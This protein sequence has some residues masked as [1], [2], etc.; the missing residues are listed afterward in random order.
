MI[1]VLFPGQGAQYSGMGAELFEQYPDLTTEAGDVL[2]YAIDRL[3]VQDPNGLLSKTR[4]TQPALYVVNALSYRAWRAAHGNS[5]DFAAGHSL[6]EYNAL[7]AA[8]VFDF[9]TGLRLVARR[10]EL[11][12][13]APAGAMAVVVG[14]AEERIAAVLRDAQLDD[15][16]IANHNT[17][18]QFVISGPERSVARAEALCTGAGADMYAKL[19]VSGPFHSRYMRDAQRQ[20]AAHVASAPLAEPR[21]PVVSNVTA[22][23]HGP[24]LSAD[25][26]RQLSS[27]VRW[28]ESIRHLIGAGVDTFRQVGVG[29]AL[30]SM[31]REIRAATATPVL[32]PSTP[33]VPDQRW[34]A[35]RV[36]QD[37]LRRARE[38][39]RL[40]G[41]G[42]M[43]DDDLSTCG[44]DLTKLIDLSAELCETL[45]LKVPPAAFFQYRTVRGLARHLVGQYGEPLAARYADG[46]GSALRPPHAERPSAEASARPAARPTDAPPRQPSERRMHARTQV[47]H[48]D[49]P[50][51]IAIVGISGVLPGA[52]DLDHFWQ[53]LLAGRDV[54]TR[55]PEERWDWRAPYGRLDDG[56]RHVPWG[57]FMRAPD[58]FDCTFFGISPQEAELMD[59]QQRL[60]LQT[61]WRAV[62]DSGHQ[63]EELASC[64]TGVFVGASAIDY[65]EV[66]SAA[67]RDIEAHTVTGLAHSLLANRVSHW[68]G[69]RGPSE[70]VDTACSSSL[71]A[72]HRAMCS[73]RLGDCD[74]AIVGGV[75]V[76]AGPGTFITLSKARMLAPD[77]R[78]KTFDVRANGYV[79]GEGVVALLI[80]PLSHA[81]RDGDH[82]HAL[83]RGSAVN[84]SGPTMSLTVPDPNAQAEVVAAAW[85]TAGLDPSTAGL[86][87][88]HGTGTALG[89]PI[90]I[91]GLR[92]A[93]ARLYAEW[94]LPAPSHQHVAVGAVKSHIGHLEPAAGSA[95]LATV[96]LAMR[97]GHLPGLANFET[98]N[99][100]L[101]LAGS[102]LR[103]PTGPEPWERLKDT[104]GRELPRRAGVS[105]FGFG[106]A[107]AHVV[108]EEYIADAH[109]PA[110]PAPGRPQLVPQQ[111]TFAPSRRPART[112]TAPAESP[113]TPSTRTSSRH[114]E[115]TH[116][117]PLLDGQ[118]LPAAALVPLSA[119]APERLRARAEQLVAWLAEHSSQDYSFADLVA[120]LQ[121]GRRAM[122][123]RLAVLTSDAATL[124]ARLTRFLRDGHADEVWSGAVSPLPADSQDDTGDQ[125][126]I[127][128]LAER[129][130]LVGVARLWTAGVPLDWGLLHPG[131][132]PRRL[133][134][135][136]YPFEERRLWPRRAAPAS[137]PAAA[138]EVSTPV[139]RTP[140][141]AGQGTTGA[142]PSGRTVTKSREQITEHLIQV[143]TDTLGWRRD[144]LDQ[145]TGFDRLGLDSLASQLIRARL[146]KHYGKLPATLVF[147]YK[148]V[149]SLSGYLAN[150]QAVAAPTSAPARTAPIT[151]PP[152]DTRA[153]DIAVI[154][155]SGRYPRARSVA[156]FWQ[157]L[158][159]GRDCI[160]EIPQDRPGFGRYAELARQRYGDAWH[161]WGGWLKDVD[162][163]DAPFFRI[164][165]IE[166]RYLDPQQ[167]LFLEV[168]WE[169]VEDAGYTPAALA[170]AALADQRGAVGVFAGVT[171]NNYQLFGSAALERGEWLA[172]E[173]QTF[174]VANRVSY[175]M[176]F[177]GPSLTVDTACSSSLY[178]VHLA[179][180]SIRRGECTAALA[181]G[182][183][184]S[185]H[186]AKFMTL[187]ETGF[188]SSDGR[189]RAF[190]EGGDGYVPA[191]A[192]GAV[193]L[194]S[195]GQ[196]LRDGDDIHAV[197]KGSAVNS[198]GRTF[199]Y[200]VPNPVAQT[201]V[202]QAA[203][204]SAGV[205]PETI[206]YVE[207]H[208]TGTSLGDPIELRGLT[209][210]FAGVTARQSCAI[211]SVKSAIG[212]AESSAGIAQLTKVVLQLRHRQLAPTLLHSAR[213]NPEI[214]FEETPFRVQL[215]AGPWDAPT[216][217]HPRRAGVSSFGAG[218]VNVHLVLEEAPEAHRAP[219]GRRR[220]V[221]LLSAAGEPN[222]RDYA[223]RLRRF[224]AE[225]GPDSQPGG[226]DAFLLDVAHTLQTGRVHLA[227]R[228]AFTASEPAEAIA[229]LDA[230][231]ASDADSRVHTG[232]APRR[233]SF[234][235]GGPLRPPVGQDAEELARAW[236]AGT[237]WAWT[238]LYRA[239]PK[240]RR[241]PLP[242]YPFS[243]RRYWL[244][245]QGSVPATP[246]AV[247][248]ATDAATQITPH[249]ENGAKS[250]VQT[251]AGLVAAVRAAPP[252][253]RC[254]LLVDHLRAELGRLLQYAPEE[255]PD[256]D[257]GFFD[258]GLDS[259]FA[260]RLGTRIEEELGVELYATVTFDYP[261]IGELAPYLLS[262]MD[263]DAPA[264]AP[265]DLPPE[266]PAERY[267]TLHYTADWE[268]EPVAHTAPDDLAEVWSAG[269]V[270]L[271][272]D[273][274]V[275]RLLRAR[276]R[277]RGCQAPV[278][279][280]R[281]GAAYACDSAEEYRVRP[282]A[283]DDW[284]RLLSSLGASRPRLPGTFV[285]LWTA[286]SGTEA[287]RTSQRR[288]DLGVRSQ[289][290][291]ARSLMPRA[292]ELTVRVLHVDAYGAA[293]PD[294]LAEA[295]SGFARSLRHENPRLLYQAVALDAD[296]GGAR[297]DPQDVL[298]VCT[299]ELRGSGQEADVRYEGGLRLVRRVR[300]V[301]PQ[302][303][304][305]PV[306]G[307]VDGGVYVITGGAGGLGLIFAEHL[308]RRARV[309]LVLS[310][311]SELDAERNAAVAR[312]AELGA[313]VT[314]VRA[315][316]GSEDGARS[317]IEQ[318]RDRHGRIDG[319]IHSAGH[320]KDALLVNKSI[321]DIDAVLAGKVL[322]ALH[323]DELTRDDDLA[324]FMTFSSLT[325]LVGNPGQADYAYANR[326]LCA[327]ARHRDRLRL[328]GERS[329]RS[330]A[331]VWPSWRHGGM[332]ADAQTEEAL[333]RHLGLDLLDTPTGTEA[334][335]L[336]LA[337]AQSEFGVIRADRARLTRVLDVLPPRG[338]QEAVTGVD[339][340]RELQ[341]VLE[342]IGL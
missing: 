38:V 186:P 36:E 231:L 23:P 271:D 180:E 68:M 264:A 228:L 342:E 52:D 165:P 116:R 340:R 294:P 216:A 127:G 34:L 168:A 152:A 289:F 242:T 46:P 35:A 224:L 136:T 205:G 108:L 147:T 99:P 29:R 64:R 265:A 201:E 188:L 126:R 32:A 329:G 109:S 33:T 75:N 277:A 318:A 235:A 53:N 112:L 7:E 287:A 45:A 179:C 214:P 293:G 326:F 291:L 145:D 51:P 156:E 292:R 40:A 57:A 256:P 39:L 21:F 203:L 77:G 86:I 187:A 95:G 133:P 69:L 54:I 106:G 341:G 4:W 171:Y 129:G 272:T 83:L 304:N 243:R 88:A 177:G 324:F 27:P 276:L 144:E 327:F 247:K 128:A 181:G 141:S 124:Q 120:T 82:I 240:P 151:A 92:R 334:F 253:E 58:A 221:L 118:T 302:R 13:R 162:A 41:P 178:A 167:R 175:L 315:D 84:H 161:R 323:L 255:P 94:G 17:P 76:M 296:H 281:P 25:L 48:R 269:V 107:N 331:L 26:V 71:A 337:S 15:V 317:L 89:D 223:A 155:M 322:G 245:E 285:H 105:S 8:G 252:S 150:R 286:T 197:I 47:E 63:V 266:Q 43:P 103:L 260:V 307:P 280:V 218:G 100:L 79:R 148:N 297:P 10:A 321:E 158:L 238:E 101:R 49:S 299:A 316:V 24:D 273:D 157:N 202:I 90:E 259:V 184:L 146:E 2:G 246:P 19:K 209:D 166:A 42:P 113:R 338:S 233:T 9:A 239:G 262:L 191:E 200:S 328:A 125:A 173:T 193:L 335:D 220:H 274:A 206:G 303:A 142:G 236:A 278:V 336:A 283:A 130:D 192:V 210:A 196:A 110:P 257:T 282:G 123:H 55:I 73:I 143:L 258:L 182:V 222:L 248:K 61:A 67:G 244:D 185:L 290:Q 5:P 288:L 227:H 93:F 131:R 22:L 249:A 308:A 132:P 170:D 309:R 251:G 81:L 211:G 332:K 250:L 62:E 87:E 60:L 119:H 12:S 174:S 65:V 31:V 164:S 74:Q 102:P 135:P 295:L 190:G 263:L 85:R 66:L 314:Y 261:T 212:H 301:R 30:D 254:A 104:E 59:P 284:D 28:T 176:N 172:V 121:T 319:L 1:A 111:A 237:D 137:T 3:C 78:C 312:I 134:L 300:E 226:P 91:E 72:L 217:G 194:K 98:P 310:G 97:H 154:G 18:T 234:A 198:D 279:L 16:D 153:E 208:G 306:A 215:E 20:F 70:A 159:R 204:R 122:A 199:G 325:A 169:C 11:M 37:L 339:V 139:G 163:F 230:Y 232:H 115:S 117:T 207:A 189:C 268:P 313:D 6:G 333:L 270:I 267:Q 311:R 140:A 219:P 225:A 241:V 149:R 44:L 275:A 330:I 96:L 305:T 138:E 80:K 195:L 14:L 160:D 229:L 213:I 183:N 320:I 56:V 50:A 298:R 114:A